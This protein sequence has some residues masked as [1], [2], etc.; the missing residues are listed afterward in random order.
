MAK[1]LLVED[2]ELLSK[3]YIQKLKRE[4]F[5]VLSAYDGDQGLSLMKDTHPDLVLL[6]IMMPKLN[7]MQFLSQVKKDH[8]TSSIPVVVLTNLAGTQNAQKALL[9]GAKCY[10]VKSDFTPDEIVKKIK[11]I[12]VK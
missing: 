5:E 11:E 1:I 10:L 7:G 4:G 8:G 3:M 9:L 12:L 6:D 2:D